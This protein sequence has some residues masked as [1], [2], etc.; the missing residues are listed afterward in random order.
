MIVC[1]DFN[2]SPSSTAY[3]FMFNNGLGLSSVYRKNNEPEFTTVK[4]REILE[5]KT[6]DYI[7]QRGFFGCQTF[8]LP[9]YQD[10]GPAGLPCAEYPS[11]HLA[12]SAILDFYDEI[13]YN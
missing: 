5:K 1:G 11:D 8:P 4:Q 13:F 7:W 12:L 3:V 6:E 9:D 10:I 2:S